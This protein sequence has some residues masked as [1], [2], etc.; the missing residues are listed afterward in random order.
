M[1][2]IYIYRVRKDSP[3]VGLRLSNALGA[4]RLTSL[5]PKQ[6][7]KPQSLILNYGRSQDA[8]W[9]VQA[10]VDGCTI[11]NKP[12]AVANAVDKRT[13]LRLLQSHGIPCVTPFTNRDDAIAFVET[14]KKKRL[15]VRHTSSG[16]KGN[17][18]ELWE[19]EQGDIP[20]APLYTEYYPKTHE[21]RVHVF[22][23][24]VIDFVQKKKMG[25]EK[26]AK[27]GITSVN[28]LVRNHKRG[29]VFARNNLVI[30]QEDIN[31]ITEACK[32]AIKA[33]GM[34]FGAVDVLAIVNNDDPR[35][36]HSFKICEVNSAPGMSD[37]NTF[38]AY[39]KAIQAVSV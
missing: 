9:Q 34:D 19:P 17:G 38:N 39:V 26:L 15:I 33:L 13:T 20:D 12:A 27:L 16:K 35:R 3:G 11:L 31:T 24:E 23:G 22:N 37:K 21:F 10:V 36:L 5:K 14:L 2:P 7:I 18:L 8:A 6:L 1:K 29:W 32:E 28:K 30:G 25:S 4:G